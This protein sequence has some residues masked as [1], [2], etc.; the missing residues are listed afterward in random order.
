MDR[1]LYGVLGVEQ[2]ADRS[3]IV[4]AYREKV[5]THHPDVSDAPDAR[6]QFRRIRT[7]KEVLTDDRVRYDNL[8]HETYVRRHLDGDQWTTESDASDIAEMVRESTT[9]ESATSGRESAT[10]SSADARANERQYRANGGGTAAAYYRPGERIG[11][12]QRRTLGWL[13]E[14]LLKVGPLLLAHSMLLV[15]T[16]VLAAWL[17]LAGSGGPSLTGAFVATTMVGITG[18]LS[19]LHLTTALFR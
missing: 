4:A 1:T 2:A 13:T 7:A 6:A 11:V 14:P 10:A 12:G 17:L 8:G 19:I 16:A 5:K 15:S 18:C 9:N 3:D